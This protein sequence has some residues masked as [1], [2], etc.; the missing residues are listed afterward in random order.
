MAAIMNDATTDR[1]ELVKEEVAVG[2]A[3]E[4]IFGWRQNT[5]NFCPAAAGSVGSFSEHVIA[6]QDAML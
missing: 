6:G 4:L 1:G 2:L 3:C 5:I